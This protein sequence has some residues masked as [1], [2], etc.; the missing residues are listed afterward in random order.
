ML[1]NTL[2]LCPPLKSQQLFFGY[3]KNMKLKMHDDIDTRIDCTNVVDVTFSL[4]SFQQLC[5]H[6]ANQASISW[7]R[8]LF[9]CGQV[10]GGVLDVYMMEPW[11]DFFYKKYLIPV[12]TSRVESL[13][14]EYVLI[15]DHFQYFSHS[16]IKLS[17]FYV[18]RCAN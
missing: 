11:N 5:F 18:N 2:E 16:L 15:M 13:I 3:E 17:N 1:H 4:Q 7:L 9:S 14:T 8:W 12:L 6:N 10:K